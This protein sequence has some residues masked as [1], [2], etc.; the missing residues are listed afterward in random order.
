MLQQ[1]A[2]ERRCN[3]HNDENGQQHF[4]FYSP[5]LTFPKTLLQK[6][7]KPAGHHG[8]LLAFRQTGRE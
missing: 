5:P 6:A 4:S 8:M 7:A 1:Q 2:R 3:S